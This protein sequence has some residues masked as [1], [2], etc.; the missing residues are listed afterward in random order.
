MPSSP[1]HSASARPARRWPGGLALALAASLALGETA[2]AAPT[3]TAAPAPLELAPLHLPF[4]GALSSAALGGVS[5]AEPAVSPV[6]HGRVASGFGYRRARVRRR[7]QFHAGLDFNAERGAPVRA[8]R[9]GIVV[10][11]ASDAER[12][13]GFLGYGNAV[14]L[15]HPD[16]DDFSFYAHLDAV[17]VGVG[18]AL[19]AGQKLGRVG[20]TSN[21]KFRGLYP[22][23]HFE[24]RQRA[25]DGSDPFP[26][27]YRDN[28]IDPLP[29]L[30]QHGAVLGRHGAVGLSCRDEHP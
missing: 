17:L 8:V 5:A 3:L 19:V 21:N 13:H 25:S 24:V 26:G 28:A 18:Q 9:R 30:V 1:L 20:N 11:V 4:K 7:R 6:E 27:P 22:H 15:Y 12:L 14:V 10:N 16:S 23:L 2:G 29:W